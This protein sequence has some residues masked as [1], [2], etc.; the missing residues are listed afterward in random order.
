MNSRTHTYIGGPKH[1][2][3]DRFLAWPHMGYIDRFLAWPHMGSESHGG[4]VHMAWTTIVTWNVCCNIKLFF[5]PLCCI[6]ISFSFCWE[7][8]KLFNLNFLCSLYKKKSNIRNIIIHYK[9]CSC[10]SLKAYTEYTS[11]PHI[12]NNN[13]QC[14]FMVT[15]TCFQVNLLCLYKLSKICTR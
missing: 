11:F 2:Y 10:T 9:N 15:A 13:I 6:Y 14:Y 12:T 3:I 1:Y 8:N 5:R 4:S 7:S